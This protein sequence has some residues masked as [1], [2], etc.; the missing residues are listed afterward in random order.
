M[1]PALEAMRGQFPALSGAPR[2]IQESLLFP[3]VEGTGYVQRLWSR[4][5]RVAPFGEHLPESTEDVLEGGAA[6]PPIGLRIAVEG[7][8]VVHDDVLGRLETGVLLDEHLG[9]ASASLADG[10][11]GDRYALV[12]L[13]GGGRALIWYA[14]WEDIAARDRFAAGMER[15]LTRLGGP[16]TLERA[17]ALG[18]PA[19]VVRIG[20]MPGVTST[21]GAAEGP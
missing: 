16:A 12:E 6:E 7:A 11:D 17:E 3:Y 9:G 19:T 1:R 21:V 14:L 8:R 15:A 2:V 4:G 5:G 10:W 13:A 18:R 20:A